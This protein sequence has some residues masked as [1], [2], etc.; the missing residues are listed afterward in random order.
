M[1]DD[2]TTPRQGESVGKG[3]SVANSQAV[4]E[5]DPPGV[6]TPALSNAAG[7][8]CPGITGTLVP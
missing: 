2:G 3:R 7:P 5:G 6:I 1:A 8:P 4:P